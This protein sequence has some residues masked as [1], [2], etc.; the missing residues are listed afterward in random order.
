V[1][2]TLLTGLREGLEAALVV[3][4][5]VAFIIRAGRRELLRWVWAGVGAAVVLS[6]GFAGVLTFTA[7]ELPGSAEAAFAG[8]TSIFAVGFVTWMVFWMRRHSRQMSNHVQGH[9]GSALSSGGRAL[10]TAAFLAVIREGLETALFL[11]PTVRAAGNGIA[12]VLGAFIGLGASVLLGRLIYRRSIKLNLQKFFTYTG[13]ALIVVAAG[14]LAHAL[15]E[16]QNIGWL[17]GGHAFAYDFSHRFTEEGWFGSLLKGTLSLTPEMTWLGA[18]T[19]VGYLATTISLFLR[20]PKVVAPRSTPPP[21]PGPN[22][23]ARA[24]S[25]V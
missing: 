15:A 19:Y 6:L 22:A 24:Q 25:R 9:V 23:S 2:Q 14:V 12:P 11:W 13:V 5:I 10:A 18:I 20:R 1:I 4:M 8:F 3:G 7:R 16:F 17:P 21:S